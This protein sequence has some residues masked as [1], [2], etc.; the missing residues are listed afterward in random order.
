[1]LDFEHMEG[2]NNFPL[3]SKKK[4]FY[5]VINRIIYESFR[6]KNRPFFNLKKSMDQEYILDSTR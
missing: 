5:S 3:Y 6:K 4:V 2:I 1:M